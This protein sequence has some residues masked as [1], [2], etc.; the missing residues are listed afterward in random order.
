MARGFGMA[1]LDKVFAS[2]AR[3]NGEWL[4]NVVT[5][6]GDGPEG[7]FADAWEAMLSGSP[8]AWSR[9][10][11]VTGQYYRLAMRMAGAP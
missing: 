4:A 6:P 10:I 9:M 3:A 7:N 1:E 2:M 8:A 11:E 5:K